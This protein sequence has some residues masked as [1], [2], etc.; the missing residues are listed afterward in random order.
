MALIERYQEKE[1]QNK[2]YDFG[3]MS[4]FSTS[5]HDGIPLVIEKQLDTTESSLGQVMKGGL[6]YAPSDEFY[7]EY[8]QSDSHSEWLSG[9]VSSLIDSGSSET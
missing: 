8:Y 4:A 2:S 3:K 1:E 7:N 6:H 9:I 5:T